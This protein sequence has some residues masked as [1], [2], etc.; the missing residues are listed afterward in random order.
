M[1]DALYNYA[2]D[3]ENP[4][5][6]FALAF[7][8][9]KI[10]QTASAITY[11]LRAADR[12]DDLDLAYECLLHIASCFNAQKNRDYT[13]I[14]LY[15]RAI[16][17]L[18]KRPE[19]Y[20]LYSRYE[21]WRTQYASSYTIATLGL[22]IADFDATPLKTDVNYPGKYG[23][24]FEKAISAYWWG[25]GK[26][27]RELLYGLADE[28]WDVM[29]QKHKDSVEN[30]IA[31]LGFGPE[32]QAFTYYEKGDYENLR[33]KFKDS[34]KIERNY[35]Q[36][37]QDMF[38]LSMLNG[39]RNGTYVEIGGGTPFIGNNTA[40]L[41]QNYDW[42]GISL[43][44]KPEF[45]EEY[46]KSRKNLVLQSD[47]LTVNYRKLFEEHFN[48]NTIDYLQL[49]IEPAK[50]TFE[51]LL[52]IPF[53]DYK[54]SVI[55]YEHDYYVDITKSYRDKS[56]RYLKL[57]GY[58]LIVNDLSPDGISN[59]EDWWI[60]PD[61]VDPEIVKIMKDISE[62]TKKSKKYILGKN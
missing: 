49:D 44:M 3:T 8:Y 58:E 21:E 14:G 30:N 37:Y 13:V 52:A 43:E 23:L 32:S 28:Y 40:L 33:F 19:A 39:K 36:I 16:S 53:E 55:T 27:S 2:M 20:F 35:S 48:T 59:F 57:M 9:E 25:K 61:L 41:E 34:D 1:D 51:V 24:I 45:V 46:K 42:K 6:N 22:T 62:K 50:N 12:T 60:H 56:R 15:Q 29:D 17:L 11:Y 18:P 10:G 47:A 7:E 38:I 54:F 26:E 4:D 5:T 31:R